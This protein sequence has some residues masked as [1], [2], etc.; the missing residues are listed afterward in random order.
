MSIAFGVLVIV[1]MIFAVV[2]IGGGQ[3]PPDI[4]RA[5][6][7]LAFTAI[8]GIGIT[9]TGVRVIRGSTMDTA[10]ISYLSLFLGV[11][12][13]CGG[14]YFSLIA[15]TDNENVL[16]AGVIAIIAAAIFLFP[17][18]LGL[19]GRARYLD[20]RAATRP[21]ASLPTDASADDWDNPPKPADADPDG[22]DRH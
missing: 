6:V 13:L 11:F 7:S 8:F 16:A 21:M 19:M 20:W 12:Y 4:D 18:C 22:Y 1:G 17:G 3:Q 5:L 2:R 9:I 15:K 10:T 14:V